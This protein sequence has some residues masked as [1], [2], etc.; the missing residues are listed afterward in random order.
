M[1]T[2]SF[3]VIG[4]VH[5][6]CFACFLS[7][8]E[9]PQLECPIVNEFVLTSQLSLEVTWSEPIY[10]D[11]SMEEAGRNSTHTSPHRF[12][13]GMHSII[14]TA[15]DVY[16]NTQN[17]SIL[18]TITGMCQISKYLHTNSGEFVFKRV[19]GVFLPL[20]EVLNYCIWMQGRTFAA[21][22]T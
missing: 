20:Q 8:H 18:I 16:G 11:N 21:T 1:S 2:L 22:I 6:A 4:D 15:W 10:R 14:Y 3:R 12:P 19:I 9:V 5:L 13:I 7:D 17:C